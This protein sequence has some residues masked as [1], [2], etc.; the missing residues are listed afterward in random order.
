MS[1]F[2]YVKSVCGD[3][4]TDIDIYDLDLN[5]EGVICCDLCRSIVNMRQNWYQVYGNPY[6]VSF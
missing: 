1:T 3:S 5:P 4:G 6:G 2:V